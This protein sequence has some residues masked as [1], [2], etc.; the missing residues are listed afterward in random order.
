M[1]KSEQLREFIVTCKIL[2]LKQKENRNLKL[3]LLYFLICKMK[4]YN[5]FVS[6]IINISK[7]SLNC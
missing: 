7:L 6:N 1:V 3:K 5:R 4:T 2:T